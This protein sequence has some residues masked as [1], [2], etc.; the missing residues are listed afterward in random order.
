MKIIIRVIIN[1]VFLIRCVATAGGISPAPVSFTVIRGIKAVEASSRE[2]ARENGMLNQYIP[3][4][5]YHLR[6]N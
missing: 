4:K 6:R 5:R 1:P 3:L 2:V